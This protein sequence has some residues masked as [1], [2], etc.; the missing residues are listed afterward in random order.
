MSTS[1][2]LMEGLSKMQYLINF[3]PLN[4]IPLEWNFDK[5]I[6]DGEYIRA[7]RKTHFFASNITQK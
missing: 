6:K 4:M 7:G 1:A 5:K 2:Y 3:W